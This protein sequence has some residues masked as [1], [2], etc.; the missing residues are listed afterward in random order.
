MIRGNYEIQIGDRLFR[1]APDVEGHY[2]WLPE[3]LFVDRQDIS[4]RPGAQNLRADQ[5]V[6]MLDDFS[7]GEGNHVFSSGDPAIFDYG[8]CNPRITG[9]LQAPPDSIE[10]DL[11][12]DA[13]EETATNAFL[14]VSGS[15]L[16]AFGD[17]SGT[18]STD[19]VAFT[20]YLEGASGTTKKITA[21]AGDHKY[22]Y[23]TIYDSST[24]T[25]SIRRYFAGDVATETFTEVS[26]HPFVGL[27]Y[28]DGYLYAL[29]GGGNLFAFDT[30][31][32]P[33]AWVENVVGHSRVQFD[34]NTVRGGICA[35]SNSIIMFASTG[36]K[37]TV[38]EFNPYADPTAGIIG[39]TFTSKWLPPKG[40]E[41]RAVDYANGVIYLAGTFTDKVAVY[42]LSKI[43]GQELFIGYIRYFTGGFTP[44]WVKGTLGAQVMIG[45]DDNSVF[46]YD[47]D[48]DAT[49]YLDR[50]AFDPDT[51]NNFAGDGETFLNRRIAIY[52]DEDNDT[53]TII[54]WDTDENPAADGTIEMI[55]GWWNFDLPGTNKILASVDMATDPL[56]TGATI[57]ISYQVEEDGVWNDL[58]IQSGD[59]ETNFHLTGST[60]SNTI[61]FDR[62]R[63][64]I[65]ATAAPTIASVTIRARVLEYI[66]KLQFVLKLQN[67]NA[68]ERG[69][70]RQLT[71]NQQRQWIRDLI[72]SKQ[73][74]TLK[75]GAYDPKPGVSTE[76]NVILTEPADQVDSADSGIFKLIAE[77]V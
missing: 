21:A 12:T 39:Q 63:F 31:L 3:K 74:V 19:G 65:A 38:W 20:A 26:V 5:L 73:V 32:A 67:D 1:L 8:A 43:S 27:A 69:T 23:Y 56:P 42:G 61:S 46:I 36:S 29:G 66:E 18:Y 10:V 54:S 33:G 55:S 15:V 4:G 53:N 77:V 76:Y 37:T 13:A 41:A 2:S 11:D 70:G 45:M 51:T 49:S 22:V 68:T 71:A 40:F 75:D 72:R 48:K 25:R 47:S 7:G 62:I 6:W 9:L 44:V 34:D 58:A 14:A 64:R 16:Y 24:N 30:S 60:G 17:A 28:L 57:T 50:P 35:T 52:R 59:G